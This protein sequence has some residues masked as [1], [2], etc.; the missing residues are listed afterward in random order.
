MTVE[1]L[2]KKLN[3]ET[4]IILRNTNGKPI[5][6]FIYKG[7]VEMFDSTFLSREVEFFRTNDN[8]TVIIDLEDTKN[9]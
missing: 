2:L 4:N 5:I 7:S 9:D 1:S 3:G 6:N 8:G